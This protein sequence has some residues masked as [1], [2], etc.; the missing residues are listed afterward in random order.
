MIEF[1][2]QFLL[3]KI[4]GAAS[5]VAG[6]IKAIAQKIGKQLMAALKKVG[7]ALK[8]GGNKIKRGATRLKEKVF[9]KKKKDPKDEKK[10]EAGQSAW[11]RPSPRSARR[12][13]PTIRWPRRQGLGMRLKAQLLYWK[14]ATELTA[15]S[16]RQTASRRASSAKVNP[17]S[18]DV[19]RRGSS[20]DPCTSPCDQVLGRRSSDPKAQ[21][22]LRRA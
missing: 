7:K 17:R 19:R 6:K 16:A 14:L 11:T 1:V 15:S 5:K 18:T 8:K 4:A 10:D 20:P 22:R 12:A 21:E 13:Q 9:G 2:S 3:R